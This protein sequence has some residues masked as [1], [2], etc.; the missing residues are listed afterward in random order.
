MALASEF[1]KNAGNAAPPRVAVECE[2]KLSK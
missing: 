1:Q 2:E